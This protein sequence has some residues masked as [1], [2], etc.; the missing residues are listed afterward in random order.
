MLKR[1]PNDEKYNPKGKY[2]TEATV[3][4]KSDLKLNRTG[5]KQMKM[6]TDSSLTMKTAGRTTTAQTNH[7][8]SRTGTRQG[9]RTRAQIIAEFFCSQNWN[10]LAQKALML[11]KEREMSGECIAKY[12]RFKRGMRKFWKVYKLWIT[13]VK[14]Q[15][16]HQEAE[17]K[18]LQKEEE[19]KLFDEHKQV[20][21]ER[22]RKVQPDEIFTYDEVKKS[23]FELTEDNDIFCLNEGVDLSKFTESKPVNYEE[24]D[25]KLKTIKE[26]K[27][28]IKQDLKKAPK[29]LDAIPEEVDESITLSP[30]HNRVGKI[31]A[32]KLENAWEKRMQRRDGKKLRQLLKNLPP[33]C[34]TSYVKLMQLKN[35]TADLQ[36]GLA[37]MPNRLF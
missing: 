8:G 18:R 31:L 7:T 37:K 12:R 23:E 19:E 27:R 5:M 35:E 36:I 25:K 20:D 30:F 3:L 14:Q 16:T 17:A 22:Q 2:A 6:S 21:E 13:K 34:R 29:K 24:Y 4:Q 33:Q 1:L 11:K 28:K 9:G 10:Y 32:Q 26:D 15:R